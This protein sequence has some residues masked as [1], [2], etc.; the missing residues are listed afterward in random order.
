MDNETFENELEL[1]CIYRHLST[2]TWSIL[3]CIGV[4]GCLL[5]LLAISYSRRLPGC[6][7]VLIFNLC[8]ADLCLLTGIPVA[9]AQTIST[10][11]L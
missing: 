11:W 9:V 8:L 7:H 6:S 5:V 1:L 2:V 3:A 4:P 10:G